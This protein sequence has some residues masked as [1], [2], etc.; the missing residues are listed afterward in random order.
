M[1]S[2]P[3]CMEVCEFGNLRGVITTLD[4][5]G[6]LSLSYLGTDPPNRSA[7][8]CSVHAANVDYLQHQHKW[9]E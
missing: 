5:E 1:P 4:E 3:V 9:P 8:Y 2:V 6:S 7:R